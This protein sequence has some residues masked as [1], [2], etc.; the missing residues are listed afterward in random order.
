MGPVA[1]GGVPAT[2]SLSVNAIV[3]TATVSSSAALNCS[4]GILILCKEPRCPPGSIEN[5]HHWDTKQRP[6]DPR[7]NVTSPSQK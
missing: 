5:I 1:A 3:N 7:W 4:E 6:M 2:V